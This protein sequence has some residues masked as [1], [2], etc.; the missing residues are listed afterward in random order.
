MD[1]PLM[2]KIE[3]ITLSVLCAALL[4]ACGDF[5]SRPHADLPADELEASF[6]TPPESVQTAVYWYWISGNISK[7]GVVKD[8]HSM[9]EAGI[10]RAFI[11]N[12]GL[13]S[14]PYGDVK[15]LSDEWWEIL[16]LALKTATELDIEIGIFNSPGWSQSGGPWVKP[17]NAMRYLATSETRVQGPAKLS[18]DLERP[19]EPFQDVSV[20]AYPAPAN[21]QMVLNASN[22]EI[23][24]QPEVS[25]L[26]TILDG[27]TTTGIAFPDE[28]TF[29]INIQAKQ[30]FTAR[31]LSI[32]SLDTPLKAHALFQAKNENGEFVAVKEFEI[33]RSNPSLHVGFVPYAPVVVSFSAVTS[34]DFRLLLSHDGSSGIAEIV[35]STAPRV[36]RYA[37]KTMAKMFQTPLPY[38]EEYQWPQQAEVDDESLVVDPSKVV[39][40][41]DSMTPDGTLN[42]NVP[43][44]D[45]VILRTGM[46]PTG[47]ENSPAAPEATGYEVDKMS[48]VHTEKHFY[49]HM[50]E[51]LRRIPEADRKSFKVVV[52][53]SYETGGQNFTDGFLEEFESVYGYDPLAWLP[54]Y[55]GVVVKSQEASDRF[56]W[57]MRRLVAD[58]VAYDYV[59]GLREV[60]HKHGLTTWLENYGHWGFPGEF[61]M[62][63]GQSD[64][65]GGEFWSE[66]ELGDIENR[67]ATSS[68]HI[69]GKTKIWAESNTAGGDQT[70]G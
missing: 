53:D 24:S 6:V 25:S 35:I 57:D 65:I 2:K 70:K 8:L 47:T 1:L 13:E 11:G 32:R 31:S 30:E 67:A 26:S 56:L 29:T 43:E 12:I 62:Y 28:N 51:V 23:T 37:E 16:H 10:N 55:Q 54:V 46:T 48:K 64:E 44:G 60:S 3:S 39:D 50:G 34:S 40:I 20:V 66:G 7:D 9:K 61:L 36:E 58:K 14:V 52:Q 21:D 45:W 63:G 22:S 27:D 49:A 4:T 38:W 42:W 59:G 41:T 33:D 69:Y 15:M 17:E 19:V 18:L 5:D 68:G